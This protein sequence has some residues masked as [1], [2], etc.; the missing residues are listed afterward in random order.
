MIRS[1]L[2]LPRAFVLPVALASLVLP[3]RAQLMIQG[4]IEARFSGI[5]TSGGATAT[6]K[7]AATPPG[8]ASVGAINQN[9]A[10]VFSSALSLKA[11][12]SSGSATLVYRPSNGTANPLNAF[13]GIQT[14][15]T[16]SLGSLQLAGN[17]LP[18]SGTVSFNFTLQFAS[19]QLFDGATALTP[20]LNDVAILDLPLK[21]SLQSSGSVAK[22]GLATPY[23]AATMFNS[24]IL[25]GNGYRL[26][27]APAVTLETFFDRLAAG[28]FRTTPSAPFSFGTIDVVPTLISPVPEPSTYAWAG[29]AL[30]AGSIVVARRR[31]RQNAA[32]APQPPGAH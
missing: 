18:S 31:Q 7:Y 24:S 16:F 13:S 17:S 9:G 5:T 8:Y 21:L 26:D 3:T 1:L 14:L 25:L 23:D 27:L 12:K 6:P 11:A 22:L 29:T 2:R 28:T 32:P 19:L 20:V 15:D 4:S 30:L 10:N